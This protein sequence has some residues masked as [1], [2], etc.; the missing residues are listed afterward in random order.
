MA[1]LLKRMAFAPLL[2]WAGQAFAQSGNPGAQGIFVTL[3]IFVTFVV[4]GVALVCIVAKPDASDP[5]RISKRQPSLALK[6]GASDV[7]IPADVV[8]TLIRMGAIQQ[9]DFVGQKTYRLADGSTV[10]SPTFLIRSLKVGSHLLENVTGTIPSAQADLLLGQSFL[11][12][13]NSW[14]IDNKRQVLLLN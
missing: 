11:R 1:K 14:S 3:V 7:S 9:S 5:T 8:S 2:A 10:P 6:E 4:F 12:R 13:F